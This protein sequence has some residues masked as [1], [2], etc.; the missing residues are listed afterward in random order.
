MSRL[1]IQ[2]LLYSVVKAVYDITVGTSFEKML[3]SAEALFQENDLRTMLQEYDRIL[4]LM[5]D[6][7]EQEKVDEPRIVQSIKNLVEKEYMKDISLNYVADKVNLA[8]AYVSYIFKKETDQTLVK[9]ITDIKMQKAKQLLEE[10]N[11]KI[12]QIG[13]ACGYENQSYFNRLFKNY[14]GVTPKQYRENV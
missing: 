3:I 11:L 7:L 2:N 12:V 10:G 14:Y 5:L 1:Y 9:Y 8:P 4:E 6:S 13:R